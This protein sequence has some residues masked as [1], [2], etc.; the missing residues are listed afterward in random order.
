MS[1]EDERE[2]LNLSD[3]DMWITQSGIMLHQCCKTCYNDAV[4]RYTKIKQP[5]Q[6]DETE[7]N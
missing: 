4:T 5:A 1:S 7:E 6:W 2:C 3:A